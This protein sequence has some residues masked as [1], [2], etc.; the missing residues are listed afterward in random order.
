MV[1]SS[2]ISCTGCVG[3]GSASHAGTISQGFGKMPGIMTRTG[4]TGIHSPSF[5]DGNYE[6][7]LNIKERI[8]CITP[9]PAG[10]ARCESGHIHLPG[11]IHTSEFTKVHRLEFYKSRGTFV[12]RLRPCI[13]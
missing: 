13:E 12:V 3:N 4:E 5:D 2:S 9:N 6:V 11:L 7:S 10:R 1:E 8:I